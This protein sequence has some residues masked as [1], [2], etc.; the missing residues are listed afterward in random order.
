M[1]VWIWK[2]WCGENKYVSGTKKKWKQTKDLAYAR[3]TFSRSH[4]IFFQWNMH[5][6]HRKVLTILSMSFEKKIWYV[7]LETVFR[8]DYNAL[9]HTE[10]VE[11]KKWCELTH[12]HMCP[13]NCCH[14]ATNVYEKSDSVRLVQWIVILILCF[15]CFYW[16][17]AK[18]MSRWRIW[19][20]QKN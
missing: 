17:A 5:K 15:L 6:S 1:D 8:H 7:I 14:T 12:T 16:N 20:D 4:F 3:L 19:L 10:C 13:S 18:Y 9:P 11:R 2:C